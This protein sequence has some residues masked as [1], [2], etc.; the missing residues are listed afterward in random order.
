MKETD[1][2]LVGVIR[3]VASSLDVRFHDLRHSYASVAVTSGM[4]LPLIGRLLGHTRAETTQRYAHLA[5]DPV[6][7]AS[8]L[9]G[10]RL[11]VAMRSEP[12]RIQVAPHRVK[13]RRLQKCGLSR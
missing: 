12:P 2:K 1:A 3:E 11:E 5:E 10:K 6:K 7:Q 13:R 8:D 9:I 4:N